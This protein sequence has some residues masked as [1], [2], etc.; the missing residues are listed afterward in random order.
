MPLIDACRNQPFTRSWSRTGQPRRFVRVS[1]QTAARGT[2]IAF[3]TSGGEV[4]L[5]GVAGLD[6]GP[7]AYALAEMLL[8]PG[9]RAQL[10]FADTANRVIELTRERQH[11]DYQDRL[12][13]PFYFHK[14]TGP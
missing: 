9:L 10:V 12:R 3:S 8:K 14:Q 6:H 13:G 7:Y 2:L 1:E 11:R 4:A 5:D